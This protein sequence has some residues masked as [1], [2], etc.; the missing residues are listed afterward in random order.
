MPIV[1]KPLCLI[2]FWVNPFSHF[3]IWGIKNWTPQYKD[4]E[5][6]K[7]SEQNWLKVLRMVQFECPGQRKLKPLGP[8]SH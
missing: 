3:Q 2:H 7:I 5:V 4:Q 6:G 8:V 1:Q